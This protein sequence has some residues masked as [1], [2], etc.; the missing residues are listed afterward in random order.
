MKETEKG[1]SW[2]GDPELAL[3]VGY[4]RDQALCRVRKQRAQTLTFCGLPSL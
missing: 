3:V 4:G 1:Q 2:I